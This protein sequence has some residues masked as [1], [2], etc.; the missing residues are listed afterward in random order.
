MSEKERKI[1]LDNIRH[2]YPTDDVKEH[3][4]NHAALC[5]CEPVTEIS[6]GGVVVIH[7]SFDGRE[8]FEGDERGH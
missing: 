2:V 4:T 8:F 6:E 5:K 1:G 7:N 3:D